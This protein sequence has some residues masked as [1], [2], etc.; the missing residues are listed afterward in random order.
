MDAM[1]AGLGTNF[2][3]VDEMG[4][5]LLNRFTKPAEQGQIYYELLHI[6]G[7][8]GLQ[9][10]EHMIDYA[11]KALKFPLGSRQELMVYMYWGDVLNVRKTEE[12]WPKQRSE[13]AAVYLQGLKRVW[14]YHAPESPPELPDPPPIDDSPDRVD[15]EARRAQMERYTALRNEA[16]FIK[17]LIYDRQI[18][19]RQIADMYHRR[20]ATSAEI[21]ALRRQAEETLG[22]DAAVARLM[23]AVQAK[24]EKPARAEPAPSADDPHAKTDQA[25]ATLGLRLTTIPATIFKELKRKNDRLDSYR[26]ALRVDDV[27]AGSPAAKEHLE[28]GDL[29]VGLHIWETVDNEQVDWVLGRPNF[30]EFLPLK[31]Y[32]FRDGATRSGQFDLSEN[33]WSKPTGGLQAR[34]VIERGKQVNGTPIIATFLELKNVSDSAKPIEIALDPSKVEFKVTNAGGKEIAQEGL[35]YDGEAAAPG[36]LRLPRGSL[37]RLSVAGNGAGVPKDQGGLLDVASS[38]NWVFKRGDVGAYFLRAKITIPKADG[39]LWSGT[40]EIPDTRIPFPTN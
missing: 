39:Q 8:S 13:A 20:P 17:E 32:I 1:R 33:S 19:I 29:L 40:I 27:R 16:D 28:R 37:L 10:P 35:P 11:Q 21:D 38:A 5:K 7:Q 6:Q 22:D 3:N 15:R 4:S 26:G 25:W 2:A 36:T 12:A 31:F 18:F 34:L 24:D 30:A 9:T 23:A 14:Q